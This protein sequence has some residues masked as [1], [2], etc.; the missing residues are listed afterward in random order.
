VPSD[1][2]LGADIE[3]GLNGFHMFKKSSLGLDYRGDYR[4]YAKNSY[5][6]GTDQALALMYRAQATRRVEFTLR[7]SAGLYSRS[8]FTGQPLEFDTTS[9]WD[10]FS[11]LQ[12]QYPN[13]FYALGTFSYA[14]SAHV[15]VTPPAAPG[16]KPAVRVDSQLHVY[17]YYN[18]DAG[19]SVTFPN[20]LGWAPDPPAEYQGLIVPKEGGKKVTIYDKALG[21]LHL[22]G[23]AQEYEVG[24]ASPVISSYFELDPQAQGSAGKLA[25]VEPLPGR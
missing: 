5:Y 13:W 17:D 22:T 18:W 9:Q 7:E 20:P 6:N 15:T 24:G 19:K 2:S 1:A 11:A 3:V 16:G 14:Y 23:L 12:G 8:M 10:K 25:P 4:H 21:R